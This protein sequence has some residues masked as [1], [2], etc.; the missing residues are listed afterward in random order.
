MNMDVLKRQLIGI[1]GAQQKE[2]MI[3]NEDIETTS[4]ILSFLP[5]MSIT[6]TKLLINL[7]EANPRISSNEVRIAIEILVE[8]RLANWEKPK[9]KH[10]KIWLTTKGRYV[11]SLP[12]GFRGFYESI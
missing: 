9:G 5:D 10:D 12:N 11:K 6:S 2:K 3:I 8:F 4:R 7:T 1:Y